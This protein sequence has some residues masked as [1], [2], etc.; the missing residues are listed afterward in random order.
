MNSFVLGRER[1]QV[2]SMPCPLRFLVLLHDI[3]LLIDSVAQG[4]CQA[5]SAQKSL[6]PRFEKLLSHVSRTA[7]VF[8][9]ES[10]SLFRLARTGYF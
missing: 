8:K 2:G 4:K 5:F 1:D 9:E 10:L 6:C 3:I 7:S